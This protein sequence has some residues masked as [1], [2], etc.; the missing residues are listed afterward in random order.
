MPR[1][2]GGTLGARAPFESAAARPRAGRPRS[3]RRDQRQQRADRALRLSDRHRQG[4]D[5]LQPVVRQQGH[6]RA[7]WCRWA[8]RP[9]TTRRR[10]GA[11]LQV[12]NMRGALVTMPH[13]VTTVGA[14]RRGDADGEDRRRVQRDA[15]AADGTLR[16]RHVRRRRLRARREAQGPSAARR[17]ARSSSAAAASARRSPHRS[18]PPASRR[19]GAV[20]RAARASPRRCRP[21]ARALSDAR[22]PRRLATT[23]RATTSSSTRRRSAWS[24]T[25]RCPSTS[26]ASRPTTFVGE[27]VMK[28][29]IT[30]LL[31]AAQARGCR[32]QVGTDMLFE[33]IPRVSRVLRLRHRD[34]RRAARGGAPRVTRTPTAR[35]RAR[36][37]K[38][39]VRWATWSS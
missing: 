7:W 5:D 34:A 11:D 6:R 18:P 19:I 32:I 24:A 15:A 17:A 27:V 21:A 3:A 9:R 31:R 36:P 13:K 26:R 30:P 28:Q 23:R 2:P 33:Q 37:A 8:S 16:R 12:T 25:I 38:E 4:A 14:A 29:A 1:A 22:R 20:R 35:R 10:A 39:R